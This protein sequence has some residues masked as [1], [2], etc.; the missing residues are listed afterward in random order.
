MKNYNNDS[1]EDFFKG[2]LV[3]LCLVV[4]CIIVFGISVLKLAEWY[5]F[6]HPSK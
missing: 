5:M 1:P 6:T 2:T 4:G 3:M